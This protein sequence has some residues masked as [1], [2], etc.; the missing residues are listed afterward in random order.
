[1]RQPKLESTPETG[2]FMPIAGYMWGFFAGAYPPGQVAGRQQTIA[3]P[4]ASEIEVEIVRGQKL[5][6]DR[7]VAL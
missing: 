5:V 7:T 4:A 6:E 1:M 2:A 3:A